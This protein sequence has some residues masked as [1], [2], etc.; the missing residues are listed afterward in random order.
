LLAGA[1]AG[2]V[3][4]SATFPLD[5]VKTRLQ[6][7]KPGPDGMQHNQLIHYFN[8]FL[9]INFYPFLK[10]NYLTKG[11]SIVSKRHISMLVFVECIEG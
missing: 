3:G 11:S 2:I 10:G 5:L 7:Q 8:Y 9:M 6:S 4:T 1:I